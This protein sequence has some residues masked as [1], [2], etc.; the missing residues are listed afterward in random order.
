MRVAVTLEQCWHRV[1]GG[2]ARAAIDQVA[3]LATTGEVD[4]VGVS[5]RHKEPPSQPWVPPILVEQLRVPRLVMYEGWHHLGW[6]HVEDATGPVDLIHATGV[7]VPPR[8][9]P[10]VVTVH[11]LAV[12]HD[13]STFTRRGASFMR[14]AIETTK[15]R[16]DLVL[17]SSRA[18]FD[19]CVA[20]G[21]AEDRL[22]LVPLGV[23]VTPADGEAVERVRLRYSLPERFVLFVGTLEPR[24]NLAGL[25]AAFARVETDPAVELVVVGPTGW[26][27]QADPAAHGLD[28]RVRALGFV[29]ADDLPAVYAAAEVLAY[30]S[31]LEGFGFPVLEAMAQG[32]PVVTSTG[33]STEELVADGGG[34]AIDPRDPGALAAAIAELL[35]TPDLAAEMGEQG[36]AMA[37]SYSWDRTARLTLDAYRELQ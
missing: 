13:P 36:R 11:D 15:E 2:T 8:S 12:R 31:L 3:A 10:L 1:P 14:R 29:P 37:A 28:G 19:D 16:A 21:F 4:L 30:P 27:E 26:G 34:R 17:C 22:R 9:V 33:T 7:A 18:T 6:P 20:D 25:L 32:T 24:K 35:D 23:V 5:A